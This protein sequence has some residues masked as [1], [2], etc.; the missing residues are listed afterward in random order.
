M[1]QD[2]LLFELFHKNIPYR[3]SFLI[4]STQKF[5]RQKR[6]ALSQRPGGQY[7]LFRTK[8]SINER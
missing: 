4:K 2:V 5:S 8:L 6:I 7:A 3:L 1:F